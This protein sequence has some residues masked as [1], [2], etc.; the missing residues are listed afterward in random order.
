MGVLLAWG[1]SSCS[2]SQ[3]PR[4]NDVTTKE[5]ASPSS[6]AEGSEP[7]T[8]VPAPADLFLVGRLQSP[9]QGIERL[10]EWIHFPIPWREGLER[11][12]PA[13]ASI[14]DANAPVD[15]AVTL[16]PATASVAP[17]PLFAISIGVKDVEGTVDALRA[18][19]R[20]VEKL[21]T[22]MHFVKV[23][24]DV[25]CVVSRANGV[26]VGR[27]VCSEAR[28]ALDALAPYMTRT[29]PTEA[30]AKEDLSMVF[31]AEPL[32]RRYGKKAHMIKVGVPLFLREVTLGNARFD[33]AMADSAHAVADEVIALI[34]ELSEVRMTAT[35]DSA[36]N[37]AVSRFEVELAGTK[38]FTAGTVAEQ[39]ATARPAPELF[40][41][42]P[43][44]VTSAS[45]ASSYS[46]GARYRPIVS[47][48]VELAL[49]G[50]E[51]FSI[52]TPAVEE[53]LEAYKGLLGLQMT[54]V[55]G[56]GAPEGA[57][58]AAAPKA[59]SK[60][61]HSAALSKMLGFQ[62]FGVEG[63]GGKLQQFVDL[64]VKV[65]NDPKLRKVAEQK[66]DEKVKHLP[67]VKKLPAPGM[68][69]GSA[70]YDFKLTP[71]DMKKLDPTEELTETID[72]QL[73][74]VPSGNRTWFALTAGDAA[75]NVLKQVLAADP[76]T[77]LAGRPGLEAL[78]TTPATTA[79]FFTLSEYMKS[80]DAIA[81]AEPD[82]K[83]KSNDV[84]LAMP[85]HGTTPIVFSSRS[86]AEG[87]TWVVELSAPKA[88]LEDATAAFV[89]LAAQGGGF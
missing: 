49:G 42:L 51:H 32:R 81:E 89:S 69:K 28:N 64:T 29:L 56:S 44:N 25:R 72:V 66:L 68:P 16:D 54:T 20:Q 34:D 45:Y 37:T 62:L 76:A 41:A 79:G 40:W 27:I 17:E 52:K 2:S 82:S 59:G 78:R 87:P 67:L 75:K 1:L 7:L 13:L 30:L 86:K 33:S 23:D 58:P 4:A 21:G 73:W 57:L 38:S 77:S 15:F 6:A 14:I 83:V 53:W 47:T 10:G 22:G 60:P 43:S 31:R 8:A 70:V 63:D 88:A 65:L 9:E 50:A 39:A 61:S 71:K 46:D 18:S 5:V 35:L 84:L 80:L 85:S 11:E 3:A 26:A 12:A 24:E 74:V 19:G 55:F 36:T 48:L